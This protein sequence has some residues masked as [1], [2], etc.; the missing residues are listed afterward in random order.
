MSKIS[1]FLD[2]LNIFKLNAPPLARYGNLA[3]LGITFSVVSLL[4]W[5]VF[6]SLSKLNANAVFIPEISLLLPLFILFIISCRYYKR[7]NRI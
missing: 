1:L 2:M 6:F 3:M 4:V 7:I 5:G